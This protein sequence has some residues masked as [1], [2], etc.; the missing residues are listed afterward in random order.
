[1]VCDARRGPGQAGADDLQWYESI[2]ELID[3]RSFSNLWFWIALA[4]MWSM[5]SH[6]VLGVPYD[7]VSRARHSGGQVQADL[8]TLVRIHTT[9]LLMIT[10]V[11]GMW[12][13]AFV[14]F[15]LSALAI[16]GFWYGVE[17]SQAVLC[18][19]APMA[20]VSLLSVRA[21][22]HIHDAHLSGEDLH[23]KLMFHRMKVQGIG[24][25]SILVTSLWGMFQN[26]QI[27]VF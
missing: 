15:V 21:A 12:I 13:V 2:F 9:R 22:H 4:V 20:L 23:R 1:V 17:F 10:R 16:T 5:A 7:M 18:L 11:A 14:T 26:L 3:M 8:E 6:W 24:M 19:L 25:V 27:G